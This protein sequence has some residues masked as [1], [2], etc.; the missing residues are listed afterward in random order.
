MTPWVDSEGT[1]GA[2]SVGTN[3]PF[4][5]PLNISICPAVKPGLSSCAIASAYLP[6]HSILKTCLLLAMTSYDVSFQNHVCHILL[7]PENIKFLSS[8]SPNR[9]YFYNYKFMSER[10][11]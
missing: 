10:L 2:A 3:F 9:Q 6:P 8:V 7:M 5:V 4:L 11:L 1:G